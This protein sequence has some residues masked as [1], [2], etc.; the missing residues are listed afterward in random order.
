MKKKEMTAASSRA[1]RFLMVDLKRLSVI[2][3]KSADVFG[4][5]KR[6]SLSHKEMHQKKVIT[7]TI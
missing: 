4:F 3:V 6:N 7:P 1:K 5:S 2:F